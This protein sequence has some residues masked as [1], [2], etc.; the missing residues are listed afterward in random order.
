[1]IASA[2]SRIKAD[3]TRRTSRVIV[4]W[5]DLDRACVTWAWR[6]PAM[7]LTDRHNPTRVRPS[8]SIRLD[9][10]VAFGVHV[11]A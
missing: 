10:S 6:T 2:A 9:T 5:F 8:P 4:L 3:W 7:Y 1:M 11:P